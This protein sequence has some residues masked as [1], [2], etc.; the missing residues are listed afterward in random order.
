MEELFW[1]LLKVMDFFQYAYD[2]LEKNRES[3][4]EATKSIA[5]CLLQASNDFYLIRPRHES[6]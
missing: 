5:N 2:E 6:F 4:M 3:V 1:L